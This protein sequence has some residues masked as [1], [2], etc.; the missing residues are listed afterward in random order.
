MKNLISLIALFLSTFLMS[1]GGGLNKDGTLGSE[2][3][4]NKFL[5]LE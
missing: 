2:E 4:L 3:D 1:H 5:K